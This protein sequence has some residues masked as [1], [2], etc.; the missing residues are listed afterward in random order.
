MV[1]NITDP[2][3]NTCK[4]VNVYSVISYPVQGGVTKNYGQ[5]IFPARSKLYK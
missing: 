3:T 1:I 4:G 2:Y 5:A